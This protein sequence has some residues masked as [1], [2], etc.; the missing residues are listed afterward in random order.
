MEKMKKS[1]LYSSVFMVLLA[2]VLTFIL[3]YLNEMT[4]PVVAFNR[5]VELQSKILYV[6]DIEAPSDDPDKISEIFGDNVTVEEYQGKDLFLYQKDGQVQAYAVPFD[7]PGL[8][9]SIQGYVGVSEDLSRISGIEFTKQ[10]ETPGLG[11]RIGE[12]PFKSQFR[13]LDISNPVNGLLVIARPAPGGN[14]DAISGATQTSTF[15]ENMVNEDLIDF[16]RNREE[17][18]NE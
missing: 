2:A 12:E 7:G 13:D 18:T 8:W 9:G 5:E 16:I 17:G 1:F 3:A 4:K 11:G 10:D 15:V 14:I 6:F